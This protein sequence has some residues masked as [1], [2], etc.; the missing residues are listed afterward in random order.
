MKNLKKH[1]SKL[2]LL[3]LIFLCVFHNTTTKQENFY[4]FLLLFLFP[5]T[6]CSPN[7]ALK[8]F[9]LPLNTLV[10]DLMMGIT[11]NK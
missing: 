11:C 3:Y 10:T 5:G 4:S 1:N 8:Y 2:F 7:K 6:F 9:G